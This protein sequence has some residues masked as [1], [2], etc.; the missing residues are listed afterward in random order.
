M[1]R[2]KIA[3]TDLEVSNICLGC[4]QFNDGG[5]DMTWAPQP[6][7]V[8]LSIVDQCFK[9]GINFF[10]TAECY[11]NHVSETILGKALQGRRRDA[12]VATKFGAN[13]KP[14]EGKLF[15]AYTAQDIENALNESLK[16]LKADYIDLYQ[17]HGSPLMANVEETVKELK[18][19]QAL[20]KIRHYG[21]SNFGPV[22]MKEFNDA[23]GVAVTNQ[24]AYNLLW[25][26]IEY[27]IVDSCEQYNCDILA[28]SG[29][30]QG[31]LTGKYLTPESLPEG[32]RRT[33]HFSGSRS[34]FSRHGKGGAE[35]LTF[36]AINKIKD[37]SEG[38]SMAATSLS[39]LVAQPR[40]ASVIVGASRPEQITENSKLISLTKE[41]VEALNAA[42]QALKEKFGSDTDQY[43][44]GRIR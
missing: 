30:Q 3:G 2:V 24:L 40:V 18:R 37:L 26:S 28:Y 10:D 9:E 22:S 21:I 23:G 7:K 36:E 38:K 6:E 43:A 35:D 11:T 31:L 25:R 8:S 16:A 39:W 33:K 19:Q 34:K 1:N 27:E 5:P 12:I 29:L 44:D 42:T 13:V 15:H 14:K 32:R 17:V 20:G 41:K 4:W